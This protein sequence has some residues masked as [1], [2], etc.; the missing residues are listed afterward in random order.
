MTFA[1]LAAVVAIV[2]ACGGATA[3]PS[4]PDI[5]GAYSLSAVNGAALPATAKVNGANQTFTSGSLTL[6]DTSYDF[7]VCVQ[8]PGTTS[9]CG[10]GFD[11][12][13]EAGTW[14]ATGQT[15]IFNHS[16]DSGKETT[17][18]GDGRLTVPYGTTGVQFLFLKH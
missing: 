8:S 2:A 13:I 1:A 16:L 17:T 3:G 11:A 5:F 18:F 6:T 7:A 4:T 9:A 10:S 14:Y 12:L 15:L